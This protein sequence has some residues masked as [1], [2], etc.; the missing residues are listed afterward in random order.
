MVIWLFWLSVFF[1]VYVYIGYPIL[2]GLLAKIFSKTI[3]EDPLIPTVTL[4]IAAYNEEAFIA[5][6]LENSLA[7]DYPHE[8]LQILVAA[9]GSDD[10]TVEIVKTFSERGIELSY[11]PERKGKMAA[12]NH[13]LSKARGEIVVMSDANN[14]Y[15]LNTLSAIVAPFSDATVGATCGAKSIYKGGDV[16]SSSEGIYWK[17]EAWIKKQETL[18]GCCT[19]A[20]GEAFAFRKSVFISPPDGII[21]DDFYIMMLIIKQGK[22]VV[23]VPD[24]HSAEHV[25]LSAKDEIE[26]RTRMVAGRYQAISHGAKLLPF[27]RPLIVWQVISH[28]F[29]RPLV[30]FGMIGAFL[31]S[32][33]SVVLPSTA[34]NF[35]LLKL[36]PPY[37][38]V[39]LIMQIVFYL[40]ALFGEQVENLPFGKWLYIPAF[41]V[42]SNKAALLGL[43]RFITGKQTT[44]WKRAQRR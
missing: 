38:W 29:L 44:L 36:A 6:K 3:Q 7:Q 24:A 32:L 21:N 2:L 27:N 40:L 14:H 35:L 34:E 41:L 18:L 11:K 19:A 8:K 1:V 33:F 5:Q 12:I 4:L 42:N 10:R 39:I 9:D 31:A 17:Y 30:P 28:K 16:L 15:N 13:A 37:N 22:R 23:Y 25:S 43:A 20:V 26:R